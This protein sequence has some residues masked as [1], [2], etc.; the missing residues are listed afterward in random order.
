MTRTRSGNTSGS[1]GPT[2]RV[3]IVDGNFR[4]F[5]ESRQAS[6]ARQD[7]DAALPGCPDLSGHGFLELFESQMLSRHLDFEA[8]AMRARE[9][10]FYTIGSAGH[11]GNAA[12]A[13]ASRHTDPAFLHYRSGAFMLERARA[14]PHVDAVYDTA[15]SLAASAE[16][17]ISGGRHK[18]WG[19]VALNVPP[20]TS[21][22]ASHLPK[23]VGTAIAHGIAG[24]CGTPRPVPDD[25]LVVCSFGDAAINHATALS[26]FNAAAWTAYQHLPCPILFVCED[27]GIGVSVQTPKGWVA[28]S[29][30]DRP[31]IRY[32]H[33]DGCDVAAAHAVAREAVDYVRRARRPAC[34]HLTLVRLLA[35][36]GSDVESRYRPMADIERDE[37]NDPL[38][39]SAA[40]A[41]DHGLVTPDELMARYEAARERVH[42]AAV[43]AARRPRLQRRAEIMAPLAPDTPSRVRAEAERNDYGAA[44]ETAFGGHDQLPEKLPPRHL[45]IQIGRALHDLLAKYKG[46][47]AF[48][49]D[50]AAKGGVYTVTSGL[51]ES[52]PPHRVFNTLLDETTIL[53]LAQGAG[54]MGLLPIP[55][56]QYLAYVHNAADQLRGE[57]CSLQFFSSGQYAN[58]MLVRIAG[59]AYQKGFGGH[60]HNDNAFAALRDI[61]GLVIACPSRGDDAASM[62]RTCAALCQ[63]DGRVV[64]F[65]EPIALYMTKDLHE[66]G[67]G[68]WL[69]PYPASGAA[70]PFGEPRVYAPEAHELLIVTFGNG[71]PM[72]LR[73][74]R[75]IEA[76]TGSR[77]RILDLRWLKP[78]NR[79]SIARHARE[80][81][82]VLVVDEERETG[83]IAEQIITSLMEDCGPSVQMA[84]VAGADSYVPLGEAANRVLVSETEIVA[85]G[86]RLLGAHHGNL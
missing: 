22:I 64:T 34:L 44:R 19:S 63:V 66:A 50:I 39:R 30:R 68:E 32:F 71:V 79:E 16:D 81:G 56:I 2:S 76:D 72:S 42:E 10:G 13:Q 51:S 58:P 24:R 35:H 14:L 3:E 45:A 75:R 52:Y 15:L 41:L 65:I 84:R 17:P 43:R 48:G 9:E 4:A 21:T 77:P 54:L 40:I 69:F 31:G 12:V 73:A 18:V 57:A 80:C 53:G 11:E 33:A 83:G 70:A 55:E 38:L 26:G 6:P 8:R 78:L 20:Q 28:A 27:N 46:A 29:F 23:A 74:A 62:L 47:I 61:P 1:A 82:R 25:A 60:F 59:L 5:V 36:A 86:R 49:E 7:P 37:A 85:A 67:D